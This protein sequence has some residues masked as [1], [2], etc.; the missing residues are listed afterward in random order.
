MST[1]SWTA[2]GWTMLHLVWVGAAIAVVAAAGRLLMRKSRPE[3]RYGFALACLAAMAV[4]P[5]VIF[6]RVV[7]P[8]W[9]PAPAPARSVAAV[10]PAGLA[11]PGP[12]LRPR[13]IAALAPIELPPT[14]QARSTIETMI[15]Y[16][17]WVWLVGSGLTLALLATGLVGVERLRR[18]SRRVDDAA[19]LDRFRSLARSL[20][21]A[22]RVG[23]AVCDRLAAPV[24]MG[25]VRPLIL[26]P[27]A[28]LGWSAEGLEMALLHELAHLR[29]WDNLVNF[30][31]RVVESLLFFHPAA[32]WLSGWVRLERELACDRLVVE[33]TGKSSAYARMLASLTGPGL[34]VAVAMA[35]RQVTTRIRRILNMEDRSMK[36]TLPEGFGLIAAAIVGACLTLAARAG[37]A[38]PK[39]DDPN[40]LAL[41]EAS[42]AVMDTKPDGTGVASGATRHRALLT[43]AAAQ[44]KVGDK[45][46]ALATLARTFDVIAGPEAENNDWGTLVSLI[47]V[48]G[49][50]REAGDPA[51]ARGSLEKVTARIATIPADDPDKPD[52]DG[53]AWAV[54]AELFLRVA[55]ERSSL[56]DNDAVRDLVR[57]SVD[58]DRA[59]KGP[60]KAWMLAKAGLTLHKAGDGVEACALLEE[61]RKAAP[62]P[63]DSKYSVL[64]LGFF[65]ETTRRV[66]GVD[67]AIATAKGF[68]KASH[69]HALWK[70]AESFADES[71]EGEAWSIGRIEVKTGAEPLKIADRE[72][73]RL[74]L[75]KVARGALE[76]DNKLARGRT[77]ALVAHMQA[78]AGDFAGATQ[79]AESMPDIARK[80]FPGP[81]RSHH[82]AIK[83]VTLAI[84]AKLQSQAGEGA[85]ARES[86]RKALDL[87]RAIVTEDQK[88]IATA[89]IAWNQAE[90]GEKLGALATCLA[91]LPST[92]DQP[93]PRR[94]RCLQI[95]AEAQAEAGDFAAATTTIDAIRDYPGMEKVSAL[96]TLAHRY[97]TAGDEGKAKD[98]IRWALVLIEAKPPEPAPPTVGKIRDFGGQISQL[99]FI[100]PDEDFAP[101]MAQRFMKSDV[102]FLHQQLGGTDDAMKAALLEPQGP[103]VVV[104]SNLAAGLARKGDVPAALKLAA[105][106]KTAEERLTAYE[107]IAYA[108]KDGPA[109]K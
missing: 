59:H 109:K 7:E 19:I 78:K 71:R 49:R 22:R 42:D 94:S 84:V 39:A 14:T 12:E 5:A 18:S 40:H 70:I 1:A 55:D 81:V 62:E 45:P 105:S 16:L 4:S 28:A 2:A 3:S 102:P 77:L 51:A 8:V 73:A 99:D 90:A 67:A 31:Q 95:L 104:T 68:D 86:F 36:L 48:A 26:L 74:G 54:K 98:F 66:S 65:A 23:L 24:L 93:E 20:G 15:A 29:R 33:R 38:P 60:M 37:D 25:V 46:S 63:G 101:K 58:L 85:A 82:D 75:S 97:R 79:T 41:R 87:A 80:D 52:D 53:P 6:L 11:M 83:P 72:A 44:L 34:G 17:P 13:P 27:P 30:A 108:I 35:D 56:G 88:L 89:A 21:I 61:A 57:R 10:A 91:I 64:A 32:W 76:L 9:R 106:L 103:R 47:Q 100:G 69:A 43:I 96:R 107:L 92:L 50:Q